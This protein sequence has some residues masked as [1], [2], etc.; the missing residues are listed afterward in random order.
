M[1]THHLKEKRIL[2]IGPIFYHYHQEIIRELEHK[3]AIVDFLPER[4]Y[5][6][7]S[8]FYKRLGRKAYQ[9]YQDRYYFRLLE[10]YKDNH[11]DYFLLIKGELFPPAFVARIKELN[12]GIKCILYQWDSM[13]RMHYENLLPVFDKVATFDPTD[14]QAYG[15]N[16]LPLFYTKVVADLRNIR[17]EEQYDLLVLGMFLPERYEGLKKLIIYAEANKLSLKYH[18]Y[19]E[20][21]HYY[22]QKMKGKAIDLNLCSFHSLSYQEVLAL[23]RKSTVIV[24]FSNVNQAG[25]SM[26]VIEAL[27]AGKKLLTTNEKIKNEAFYDPKQIHVADWKQLAIPEDFFQTT[28]HDAKNLDYLRLDNWLDTLFG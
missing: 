25:L 22:T 11:Y 17:E 26:R 12:P 28:Y 4:D 5:T 27:G 10:D 1:S 3:G 18:I 21:L 9:G 2:F 20:K 14:S 7:R 8:K 24:D 6:V 15:L 19:L 16:Y 23:Y 13:K